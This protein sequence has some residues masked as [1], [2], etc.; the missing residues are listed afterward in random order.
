M[1]LNKHVETLQTPALNTYTIFVDHSST[2]A[3]KSDFLGPAE[4]R[5]FLMRDV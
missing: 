3:V 1:S 5:G 4:P 2:A